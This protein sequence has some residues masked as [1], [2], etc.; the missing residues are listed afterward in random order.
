[1]AERS[2]FASADALQFGSF[3]LLPARKLLLEAGKPVRL[4]SRALEILILLVERAGELVGKDELIA[5]VWPDTFVEEGSL[6]VH[7]AA[8][9]RVLGDGQAGKRYIA[10]ISGR[11]YQFI[12]PVE[13]AAEPAGASQPLP[14]T[15]IGQDLPASFTRIIGRD[16]IVHALAAQ[17]KQTRFVTIVGPGGIGKTTVALAMSELL[18]QSFAEGVRF[19]DLTLIGS[20]RLVASAVASALGLPVRS[21]DPL[22]GVIAAL[23]KRD[24]L[25]VLDNCEHVIEAVAMLAE[26]LHSGAPGVHLLATS[27]EPMRAEGEQVHRL[28]PLDTPSSPDGLTAAKALT[29]PAV[30]LFVERAAASVD[31]FTLSDADAPLVVDICRRLDGIALAIELAAGRVDAFGVAGIAELLNYRFR[32][33]LQGRRTALPRHQTLSAAIDWSY[34]LLPDD[35]RMIFRRMAVFAGGATLESARA[36]TATEEVP[37]SDVVEIIANLVAK[38]LVT[39]DVADAAARYRLLDTTRAYA[40]EKLIESGEAGDFARRHAE[41]YTALF[42]RAEAEWASR[43]GGEGLAAHGRDI[44]NMRAAL[45]WAFSPDGDASLGMALTVA[46]EPLWTHLSLIDEWRKRVEQALAGLAQGSRGTRRHM[47]LLAALGSTLLYSN[48]ADRRSTPEIGTVWSGVREIAERL[49]DIDYR[50]KALWGLWI[51]HFNRGEHRVALAL[52]REFRGLAAHA[53]EPADQAVGDRMIGFSLQLLGEFAEARRHIER[54]LGSYAAPSRRSHVIRF[55]FDQRIT[56]EL[57]LAQIQWLEG[58]PDQAMRTV[59]AGI[60]EALTVDHVM[61][62]CN[63]LAQAGC[64]IAL[65]TGDLAA[66]ERFIALLLDNASRHGLRIWQI[67]GRCFEG[68]LVARSGDPTAG[69]RLFRTAFSELQPGRFAL[70]YT[71]FLGELAEALCHA[72]HIAQGVAAIDQALERSMRHEELWC[73]AELLRIKGDILRKEDAAHAGQA[74]E[75]HMMQALG[76]AR[77]QGAL[78]WELRIAMSM[79]RY[80]RARERSAEARDLVATAYS[81]FREGFETADLSAARNL[82]DEMRQI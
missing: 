43:V 34:S 69:L 48:D 12:A 31:G 4:G 11:G 41:H 26:A 10:S 45:D 79:A 20:P 65:L 47:Q 25:I 1:M 67:W 5:R 50:L 74:S 73:I 81:R 63:I 57:T 64:P 61:S 51:D 8:L 49:E 6:R 36:V 62:L 82:L 71:A 77:R 76:W 24:I 13:A 17:L 60:K 58:Y 52:A 22:A 35:E 80:W 78:S 42:E 75:E 59:E 16:D 3:R 21:G 28:P 38:S 68:L 15:E 14:A 72:G 54:M 55:Q 53:S 40:R 56:A 29:F 32:L 30:Q 37:A 19:V 44:D 27:R 70:R 9:R 2:P 39:A 46:G 23:A 66:A 33:L 18:A 7:V